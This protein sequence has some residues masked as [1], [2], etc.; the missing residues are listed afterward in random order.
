MEVHFE[1]AIR[2][3]IGSIGLI[4]ACLS[5]TRR[6]RRRSWGTANVVRGVFNNN[7]YLSIYPIEN[8]F[9][10]I[11]GVEEKCLYYYL[12]VVCTDRRIFLLTIVCSAFRVRCTTHSN[13]TSQ[14]FVFLN[15]LWP[16]SQF[17]KDNIRIFNLERIFE[18][19]FRSKYTL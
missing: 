17:P 13:L 10:F 2:R 5:G 12:V 8:Y 11:F 6:R 9:E 7:V 4:T 15:K 16:P 14:H 1:L 19:S 3:C 18:I